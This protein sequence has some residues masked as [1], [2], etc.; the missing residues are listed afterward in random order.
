MSK[1]QSIHVTNSNPVDPLL[2]YR[3]GKLEEAVAVLS[4][5]LNHLADGVTDIT[6]TLKSAKTVVLLLFGIIQPVVLAL[7]IHMLTKGS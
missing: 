5:S 6:N 7:V 3:V 1:D 4:S 2:D